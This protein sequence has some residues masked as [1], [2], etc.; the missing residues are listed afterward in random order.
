MRAAVFPAGLSPARSRVAAPWRLRTAGCLLAGSA[1]ITG[2]AVPPAPPEPAAVGVSAPAH[3]PPVQSVSTVPMVSMVP[4][5]RYGRYTLVELTPEPAQ[6][7]LM[8]QVVDVT[9]PPT[10]EATV[11]AAMRHV[12]LGTGYQLCD[13]VDALPLFGLPLPAAHLH[14]GPLVLRDALQTLAGPAWDLTVDDAARQVCVV[15]HAATTAAAATTT[16]ETMATP[17]SHPVDS[18]ATQSVPPATQAVAVPLQE[19]P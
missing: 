5:I 17:G 8:Q 14:L 3:V 12:L 13:S 6:R 15:R 9:M 4:V 7:D 19:T 16:P 18:P 11:G 1:F 2:C 10:L